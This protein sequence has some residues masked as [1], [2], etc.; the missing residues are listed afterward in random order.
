MGLN[1][2]NQETERLAR[3]LAG[4]TGE[5]LTEAISVALRE[6]LGHVH[7]QTERAAA[8]RAARL[9]AIAADAAGRWAEPYRTGDHGTLLYDEMGLP[10]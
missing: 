1:I 8:E 7:S 2:K 9:R 4:A 3:E 5:S 6:R 10:R